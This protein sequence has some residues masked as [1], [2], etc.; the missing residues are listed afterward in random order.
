MHMRNYI[1]FKKNKKAWSNMQVFWIILH[2]PLKKKYIG[3]LR[4]PLK[5][6][7]KNTA[8]DKA[9]CKF[10]KGCGLKPHKRFILLN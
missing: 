10:S 9:L 8:D 3:V 7:N 2:R 6:S 4:N 5:L 1:F